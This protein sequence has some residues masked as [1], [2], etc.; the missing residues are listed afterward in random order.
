MMYTKFFPITVVLVSAV[1]LSGLVVPANA[2]S[3]SSA[4]AATKATE[5]KPAVKASLVG[6]DPVR[7]EPLSQTVPIIGR[8]V[9][10]Q[11]GQVAAQVAGAVASVKVEVGDRMEKGQ[12]IAV[13]DVDALTAELGVVDG[14]LSQAQAQLNFDKS[15]LRLAEFGLRRQR[16]L[17]KS[18]AFSKAKYEDWEQK[19]ARAN[20]SV[21][22]REAEVSTKEASKRMKEIDLAKAIIRAPYDGVV[23]QRMAEAGSYVRVGDPVVYMISDRTLEIEADV[24]SLRVAGMKPGMEISFALDNGQSFVALVRAILPTENPLTR[25]RTVR[26]EPD[27]SGTSE[28]FAD[29]QSVTVL[30]PVGVQRNIIS[31]HKD[32]IVKRGSKDLVFV[33][34]DNKA[35][36]RTV[37]LGEATGGRI[38]VLSGLKQGEPVVVRGNERLQDGASVKIN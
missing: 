22:K 2:Q 36:P 6:V 9:A 29:A 21:V 27:F 23:T 34:A 37:K 26:F 5:K 18:G 19:V 30:V 13:L 28:R 12:V 25:T 4:K 38:E 11:A 15:D 31:V 3:T 32:A 14:E 20:A 8:L 33:V 10:R 7:L 17:K 16:D 24:P 35:E 1:A